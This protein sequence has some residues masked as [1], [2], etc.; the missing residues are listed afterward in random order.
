MRNEITS[1]Q[2]INNRVIAEFKD[3]GSKF[4][5][6]SFPVANKH[7]FDLEL[8]AIKDE[9]PKATHYCYA[10]KIGHDGNNF[11]INDDG[12]P[13]GT[14]GKPIFS[15]IESNKLTNIAIVVVRYYGG[16][17]LGVPGLIHAYK[18][19]AAISISENTVI[20]KIIEKNFLIKFDSSQYKQMQVCI[21]QL[22]KI[23]SDIS[24]ISTLDVAV[25][26]PLESIE[27]LKKIV[28]ENT[29]GY[30]Y[31]GSSSALLEHILIETE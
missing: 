16:T 7:E 14:A 27:N 25:N 19:S 9:F 4:F 6:I 11:R 1:Y 3:K 24:F 22:K 21:G 13:S 5:A 20:V 8:A 29:F 17:K 26:V 2:T 31:E 12:E 28:F 30:A 10:Y 18:S 15:Q 23:S